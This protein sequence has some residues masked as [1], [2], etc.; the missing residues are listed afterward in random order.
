MSGY[1]GLIELVL[2]FALVL[3]WGVWEL[4]SVRRATRQAALDAARK[5]AKDRDA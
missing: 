1:F 3:G 2:V 5:D 4:R